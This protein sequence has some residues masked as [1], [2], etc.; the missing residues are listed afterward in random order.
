[1]QRFHL[2]NIIEQDEKLQLL[3]IKAGLGGSFLKEYEEA[4]EVDAET[5]S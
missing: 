1:M 3:K 5:I 2:E 4:N